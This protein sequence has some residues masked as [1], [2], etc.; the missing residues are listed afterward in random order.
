LEKII[1]VINNFS[2]SA[3]LFE[4]VIIAVV[5]VAVMALLRKIFPTASMIVN[6]VITV[7]VVILAFKNLHWWLALRAVAIFLVLMFV[8]KFITSLHEKPS[9][10]TMTLYY[11]GKDG[12][13]KDKFKMTTFSKKPSGGTSDAS[14]PRYMGQD[15]NG[16]DVFEITS[17]K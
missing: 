15:A 11:D 14:G 7:A 1:G 2:L 8:V 6:V 13:G 10:A 9:G 12:N 5:I 4:C 16:N 17:K 3:G